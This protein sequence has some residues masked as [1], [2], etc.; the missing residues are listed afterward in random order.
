M[1][2]SC[3]NLGTRF[4]F[5]SR[6]KVLMEIM[7]EKRLDQVTIDADQSE[8]LVKLLD[9]I[10][11]KLEGGTETDLQALEN[12]VESTADKVRKLNS[13][14]NFASHYLISF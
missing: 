3:L 14:F 6:M 1:I 12:P 9:T 11:I 4:H 5:Q 10:V 8:K 13:T 2:R 7:E